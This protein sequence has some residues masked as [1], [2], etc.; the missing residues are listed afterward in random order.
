M[1]F[2]FVFP[3]QDIWLQGRNADKNE[4]HW[5]ITLVVVWWQDQHAIHYAFWAGDKSMGQVNFRE[6]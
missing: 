4:L 2:L 1:F 3:C 5:I 6:E